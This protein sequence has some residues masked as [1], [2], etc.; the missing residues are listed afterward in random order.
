MKINTVPS[1]RFVSV[2]SAYT[3]QSFGSGIS[4]G[5][6]LGCN[7]TKYFY[8]HQS[9]VRILWECDILKTDFSWIKRKKKYEKMNYE[10]SK[11]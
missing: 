10:V 6:S 7:Y 4:R 3:E 2:A 5:A 1:S 8:I 9:A 11:E